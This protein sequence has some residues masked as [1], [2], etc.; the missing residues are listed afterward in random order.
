[1]NTE[2]TLIWNTKCATL[3]AKNASNWENTEVK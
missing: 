3:S 1:M 2:N